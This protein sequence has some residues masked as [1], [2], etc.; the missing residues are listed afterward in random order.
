MQVFSF[1]RTRGYFRNKINNEGSNRIRAS[2]ILK[3]NMDDRNTFQFP[4]LSDRLDSYQ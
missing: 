3:Q 4:N 1:E 2:E